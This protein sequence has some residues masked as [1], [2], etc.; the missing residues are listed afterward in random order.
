MD[1]IFKDRKFEKSCNDHTLLVRRH[2]ANMAK[3]IRRRM[4]ELKAADTLSLMK[5]LPHT[6]CHELHGSRHGDLSVDLEHP[7]RLIFVPANNPV[8]TKADGGLDWDK[9]TAIEIVGI[10]DTHE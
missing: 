2:G 3:L 6:R 7:Y 10:E 8:P 9:V 4:D 5:A 1:I